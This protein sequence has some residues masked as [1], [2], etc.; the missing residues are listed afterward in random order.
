M[1]RAMYVPLSLTNAITALFAQ[2]R[3]LIPYGGRMQMMGTAGHGQ[4]ESNTPIDFF[5]APQPLSQTVVVVQQTAS[6]PAQIHGGMGTSGQRVLENIGKMLAGGPQ[7]VNV[8]LV[9]RTPIVPRV[10]L[11]QRTRI[12]RTFA[13]NGVHHAGRGTFQRR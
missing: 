13:L 11:E 6:N 4:D 2:G 5:K 7:G 3:E 10:L 9:V 8:R 12:L 1:S